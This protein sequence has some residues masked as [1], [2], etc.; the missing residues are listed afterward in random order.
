MALF[1]R[2]TSDGAD[3]P[4]TEADGLAGIAV[5]AMCADG[6]LGAEEDAQLALHVSQLKPFRAVSDDELH[7]TFRRAHALAVSVG[8]DA[9]LERYAAA[10]SE[11]LRPTA[12]FMAADIV[13]GDDEF[14]SDERGFLSRLQKLLAIDDAT[15]AKVRE[16]VAIKHR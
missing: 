16:V 12:Y 2:S 8:D 3:A 11:R 14:G 6:V 7:E 10:V 15:A 9:A 13:M 5:C 1:K 4:M